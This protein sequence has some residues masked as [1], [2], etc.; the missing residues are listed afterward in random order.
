MVGKMGPCILV[1]SGHGGRDDEAGCATQCGRS[2]SRLG[3]H[4]L[5]K[6]HPVVSQRLTARYAGTDELY[7][8]RGGCELVMVQLVAGLELGEIDDRDFVFRKLGIVGRKSSVAVG[9]RMTG[10]RP[11]IS[12]PGPGFEGDRKKL[13]SGVA[14]PPLAGA[15]GKRSPRRR[16]AE[17]CAK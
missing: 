1:N 8:L 7:D 14:Q 3:D 13:C 9:S 12:P 17:W 4:A 2:A 10:P 15:V 5:T 16:S 11:Q 6:A